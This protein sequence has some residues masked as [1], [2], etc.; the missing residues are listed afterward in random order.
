M[1]VEASCT[2]HVFGY[3]KSLLS[4]YDVFRTLFSLGFTRNSFIELCVY[5]EHDG[6]AR[7]HQLIQAI[8]V[9]HVPY[10][11]RL[12]SMQ[13]RSLS[14]DP[15]VWRIYAWLGEKQ[16]LLEN[17]LLDIH[18]GERKIYAMCI[19]EGRHTS[20]LYLPQANDPNWFFQP[21]KD[22]VLEAVCSQPRW[23]R[24]FVRYMLPPNTAMPE[25]AGEL[26]EKR[27]R[28]Y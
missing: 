3:P 18:I 21:W 13:V 5:Y 2:A 14:Y 9:A 23:D 17:D 27:R 1:C 12:H 22:I 11:Y 19:A 10:G 26:A 25:F 15:N 7:R 6:E 20:E 8:V 28:N 4:T 16:S 24:T